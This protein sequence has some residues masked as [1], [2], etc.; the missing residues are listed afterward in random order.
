MAT[1]SSTIAWR[2]PWRE[3]PGRLQSMGS[4]SRTRLSDF[5]SL[6]L[7]VSLE[8][9]SHC[10]LLTRG[11]CV[12]EKEDGKCRPAI[13]RGYLQR[14]T[15]EV[16]RSQCPVKNDV[17]TSPRAQFRSSGWQE[18]LNCAWGHCHSRGEG[19]ERCWGVTGRDGMN[20]E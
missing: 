4:Q 9:E 5:T 14:E 19:A 15:Q 8:K 16:G 7:Q 13:L 2:I 12:I 20:L 10:L 18:L 1:H 6:S 3:E 11:L 17:G